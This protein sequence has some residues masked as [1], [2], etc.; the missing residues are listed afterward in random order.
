MVDDANRITVH[1]GPI[2]HEAGTVY[3][4]APQDL[5]PNIPNSSIADKVSATHSAIDTWLQKHSLDPATFLRARIGRR[6]FPVD[7]RLVQFLNAI[8]GLSRM[9]WARIELPLDILVKAGLQEMTIN[10]YIVFIGAGAPLS[11]ELSS[12]QK[13]ISKSKVIAP[14]VGRKNAGITESS[15][16]LASSKLHDELIEEERASQQARLY[17]WMYDPTST[18]QLDLVWTAFGHASWI[19]TIPS[20]H[21]HK[22]RNTRQFMENRIR[23]IWPLLHEISGATYAQRK[24]S[25]LVLPLRNFS[26]SVTR[27]LK[28]YWYNDLDQEQISRKIRSFKNRH[29]QTRSK[30]KNG[31]IDEKALVFRPANDSECHGQ[32]HPTGSQKKAF[33]CGRFRFGVSLFPGFHFDVSAEKSS[34]I[35][36]DLHTASGGKRSMRSENRTYINIFPNDFL[37]PEK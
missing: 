8:E 37:L 35:Q 34:S 28:L 27:E 15:V 14:A 11:D 5:T 7:N 32:A 10:H 29:L 18:E 17:L 36:C 1:D 24:T 19:E 25:P 30:T 6:D 21:L 13:R 31:Y 23:Q 20:I 33:F 22:A 12:I 16:N 4:I 9:I 26:S 3:E 2:Q